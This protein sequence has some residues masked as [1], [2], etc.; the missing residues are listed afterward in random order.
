MIIKLPDLTA[1]DEQCTHLD[2]LNCQAAPRP[3]WRLQGGNES[4]ARLW[5]RDGGSDRC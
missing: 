3:G 5:R 2:G 4:Y 1:P